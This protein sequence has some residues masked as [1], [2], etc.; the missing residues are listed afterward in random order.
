MNQELS[1]FINYFCLYEGGKKNDFTKIEQIAN[2]LFHPNITVQTGKGS[3]DREQIFAFI[4]TFANK[5]GR[6]DLFSIEVKEHS[7]IY[8]AK[9]TMPGGKVIETNSTATFKD[10]M[11]FHVQPSVPE[12]YNVFKDIGEAAMVQSSTIIG[13]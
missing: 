9:V 11:L 3:M 7:I 5:G 4:K 12:K 10:R 6:T 8:K 1:S 2:Q 13:Q